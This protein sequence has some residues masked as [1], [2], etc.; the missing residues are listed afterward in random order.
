MNQLTLIVVVLVVYMAAMLLIGWLGRSKSDNFDEY[1]TAAKKGSFLLVCGS[2]IGS[3][4]GN[5]V[6]V[7]GAQ[8]GVVYGLA[9]VWYGVG[10]CLSY[11]VYAFVMAKRMKREDC[12]TLSEVIDKSYGGHACGTIYAVINCVRLSASWPVRLLQEKICSSISV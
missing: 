6:V 8:N 10:A 5:G 4:I 3:H 9:G 2:Y 12:L 1:V 7:G 11:L